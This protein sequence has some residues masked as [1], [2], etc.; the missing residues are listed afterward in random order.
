M[1]LKVWMLDRFPSVE[2]DVLFGKDFN[3]HVVYGIH[4]TLQYDGIKQGVNTSVALLIGMLC[5]EKGYTAL[6]DTNLVF[7]HHV[8]THDL[9]VAAITLF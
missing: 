4:L 5:N 8:V 7:G 2:I 6:T 3:W 9:D 1:L